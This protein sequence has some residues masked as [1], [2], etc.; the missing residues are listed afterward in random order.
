VY[1][2]R[3]NAAGIPQGSEFH[4]NTFTPQLQFDSSVAMDAAGNFVIVWQNATV[5]ETRRDV[6]GQRYNAAGVPQGDEFRVNADTNGS[7][8]DPSIAVDADGDFAVVF[9]GRLG[10]P[11]TQQDVFAR[12]YD[13]SGLPQGQDFRV[14]TFTTDHQRRVAV[15]MARDGE[16][17]V[18]WESLSQRTPNFYSMHAQRYDAA[19]IAVGGEFQVSTNPIAPPPNNNVEHTMAMDTDG[20]FVVAWANYGRDGSSYGVYAQRFG[21]VTAPAPAPTISASSFHFQTAPHRLRF[22][23]DQNVSAS[24]GTDDLV[25]QNL[26]TQQTIPSSALSLTYDTSTNTATFTYNG[27]V[28]PDGRYRAT[29]LAAG[30]TNAGGTPIAA[31]HVFEFFFLRGDAN[32]DARVNLQDFNILAGNFGQTPRDF[33]QGDFN[34][35]S[36][37]NLHDFNILA[38]R[39]GQALGPAPGGA[40]LRDADEGEELRGHLDK[41]LE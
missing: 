39:F 9:T 31:D 13:E 27:N 34:Y 35:D 12:R 7:F 6:F 30:I 1:A 3:Y 25:L 8:F 24:L 17:A 21:A 2:Q 22:A 37:V 14:N 36:V 16:F 5:P 33:A 20:D 29:L 38:G 11:G 23:F 41:L 26:T 10:A 4:V 40:P 28:L 15:A 32:H 18:A 19:G